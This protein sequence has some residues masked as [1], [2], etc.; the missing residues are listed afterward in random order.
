MEVSK[1]DSDSRW[2]KFVSSFEDYQYSCFGDID[3]Y[4]LTPQERTNIFKQATED[5][6]TKVKALRG[7]NKS[8]KDK[9]RQNGK[10]Y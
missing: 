6:K 5:L 1:T 2:A 7:Q 4:Y 3:E 8:N 10:C 9:T